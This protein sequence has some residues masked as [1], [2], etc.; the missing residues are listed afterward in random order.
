MPRKRDEPVRLTK[1]YTRGGDAGQ[2]SLGDGTRVSKLDPR[3]GAGGEVDE[4]NS[5]VGWTAVVAD[6]EI[7]DVLARVENNSIGRLPHLAL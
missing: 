3:V 4:L 2:T 7:S 6:G 1:I 5:L